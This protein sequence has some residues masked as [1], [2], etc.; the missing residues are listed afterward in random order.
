MF[1]EKERGVA[2]EASYRNARQERG[3]CKGD[4]GVPSWA[5]RSIPK[6]TGQPHPSLSFLRFFFT[7]C[8][9]QVE[10]SAWSISNNFYS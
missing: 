10:W 7:T 8:S 3:N 6:R 1:H 4:K 9:I 5:A 2:D